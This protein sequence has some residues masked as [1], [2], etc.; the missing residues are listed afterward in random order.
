MDVCN[1]QND[2]RL[3]QS[4]HGDTLRAMLHLKR[5]EETLWDVMEYVRMHGEITCN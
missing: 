5:L 3:D 4:N 1:A 2:K